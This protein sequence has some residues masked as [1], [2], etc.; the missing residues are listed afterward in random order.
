[1]SAANNIIAGQAMI[2]AEIKGINKAVADLGRLDKSMRKTAKNTSVMAKAT[3]MARGAL[4]ALVAINIIQR[5]INKFSGALMSTVD[6]MDQLDKASKRLGLT[7]QE[8]Q[9]LS[10]ATKMAGVEFEQLQTGFAS[11]QR[12][13]GMLAM[14]TGEAKEAFRQ[15][16]LSVRDLEGKTG[17]QQIG[18]IADE[19]N[20]F[21]EPAEKGALAMKIFGEG[22]M[23]LLPFLNQGSEGI[24][25]LTRNV[26]ILTGELSEG[27]VSGLVEV[28]DLLALLGETGNIA[29]AEFFAQFT[30]IIRV[31]TLAMIAAAHALK[32]MDFEKMF[33]G[34]MEANIGIDQMTVLTGALTVGV[35]AFAA[36]LRVAAGG[37]AAF[38]LA[39]GTA[40]TV[41]AGL[42]KVFGELIKVISFGA[43]GNDISMFA[44]SLMDFST[45]LT[46]GSWSVL[47]STVS[48]TGAIIGEIK[49]STGSIV[50]NSAKV[51]NAWSNT[52]TEIERAR[53]ESKRLEENT[54]GVES[55]VKKIKQHLESFRGQAI[56][57]DGFAS[58]QK[59]EENRRAAQMARTLDRIE[60]N[61]RDQIQIETY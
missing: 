3:K 24:Q 20:K 49:D 6:A 8:F 7:V 39:A 13:I 32:E 27:A 57:F 23:R 17:L 18:I 29:Q 55:N 14:G 21:S 44:D 5:N 56:Q 1:M 48:D 15:L 46:S 31:F 12:N 10:I 51:W 45:A 9:Q 36:G 35:L 52:K 2:L 60:R 28:K 43:L 41:A 37:V 59:F 16:G 50:S 25:Q 4:A 19:L 38:T 22:G 40:S 30:D 34:L 53:E 42:L 54:G 58:E 61:T 11:M 26:S 47:S 33:S